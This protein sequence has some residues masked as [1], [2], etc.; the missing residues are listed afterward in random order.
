MRARRYAHR[1]GKTSPRPG[2]STDRATADLT[3]IG[4]VRVLN[5]ASIGFPFHWHCVNAM[6]MAQSRNPNSA[7][8]NDLIYSH[9]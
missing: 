3:P 5:V 2:T 8:L 9:I 1:D 4:P 6:A 7:R